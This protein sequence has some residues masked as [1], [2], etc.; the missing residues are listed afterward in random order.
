MTIT[1]I[2]IPTLVKGGLAADDRGVLGFVNDLDLSGVKR[3][4]TIQNLR[5]EFKRAWHGH[6]HEKK[7]LVPLKGTWTVVAFP[8]TKRPIPGDDVVSESPI[9]PNGDGVRFVLSATSPAALIIPGGY[10]HGTMN[11]TED[12]SLLIL[13]DKTLAESQGDDFRLSGDREDLWEMDELFEVEE[14]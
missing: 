11:L 13:S 4:Y 10:A 9:R 5:A 7:V 14:R 1:D 3:F 8:C 12:A 2:T 6:W